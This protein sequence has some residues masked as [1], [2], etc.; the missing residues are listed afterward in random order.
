MAGGSDKLIKVNDAIQLEGALEFQAD[1]NKLGIK[2][3]ADFANYTDNVVNTMVDPFIQTTS[4]TLK[5]LLEIDN[6]LGHG[7]NKKSYELDEVSRGFLGKIPE[8]ITISQHLKNLAKKGQ[9]KDI[10]GDKGNQLEAIEKIEADMNNII[11]MAPMMRIADIT[12]GESIYVGSERYAPESISQL[13]K[14]KE[15][16]IIST[17]N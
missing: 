2:T 16:L 11:R 9:L 14:I 8:N 4:K 17:I 13:K 10:L 5:D 1:L 3:A 12:R 6:G 15:Y 7:R